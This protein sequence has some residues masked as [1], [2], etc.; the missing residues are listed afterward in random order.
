[1]TERKYR[2]TVKGLGGKIDNPSCV[3]DFPNTLRITTKR[4]ALDLM[5]VLIHAYDNDEKGVSF[6]VNLDTPFEKL[7][8]A[9]ERGIA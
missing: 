2:E 4:E 1:M 7:R 6:T 8:D 5:D 3:V 9:I